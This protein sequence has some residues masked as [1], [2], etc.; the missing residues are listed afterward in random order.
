M[1]K[2]SQPFQWFAEFLSRRGNKAVIF[3][4]SN[5][6]GWVRGRITFTASRHRVSWRAPLDMT[7]PL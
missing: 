7:C 5:M 2:L 6:H 1:R 4:N 3:G